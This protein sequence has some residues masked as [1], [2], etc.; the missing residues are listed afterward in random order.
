MMNSISSTRLRCTRAESLG[1]VE[2]LREHRRARK[3]AA[4]LIA[5]CAADAAATHL[6]ERGSD[7][8]DAQDCQP[9]GRQA[10]QV[11]QERGDPG[12]D[13]AACIVGRRPGPASR[14]ARIAPVESGEDQQQVD[15]EGHEQQ[16]LRLA[17]QAGEPGG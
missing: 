5:D 6:R 1:G 15:G 3:S 13:R 2:S 16:P 11:Q 9:I 4:L 10:E 14:E 12:A 7:G 8:H 17:Q